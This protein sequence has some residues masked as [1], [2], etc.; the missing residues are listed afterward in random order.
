MGLA[1][2]VQSRASGST[3]LEVLDGLRR[4]ST[5]RSGLTPPPI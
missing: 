4:L 1:A 5:I 2:T 3:E